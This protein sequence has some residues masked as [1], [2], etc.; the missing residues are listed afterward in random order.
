MDQILHQLEDQAN[1][2]KP[3]QKKLSIAKA[4]SPHSK[5]REQESSYAA[6]ITVIYT[7]MT[8]W[9]FTICFIVFDLISRSSSRISNFPR[10]GSAI[11]KPSPA[12]HHKHTKDLDTE[13]ATTDSIQIIN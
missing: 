11:N 13:A 1:H 4:I 8:I 2:D 3:E 5:Q 9:A 12:K 7:M 6:Y 10:N